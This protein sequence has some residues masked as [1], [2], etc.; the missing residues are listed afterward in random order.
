MCVLTS[1]SISRDP[2]SRVSSK[3]L[4]LEVGGEMNTS[5]LWWGQVGQWAFG[6]LEASGWAGPHNFPDWPI[7]DR[8][9]GP[10][11]RCR[12]R[13]E[14]MQVGMEQLW[15]S[16]R[17]SGPSSQDVPVNRWT[18]LPHGHPQWTTSHI[19]PPSFVCWTLPAASEKHAKVRQ[20]QVQGLAWG[21]PQGCS[22]EKGLELC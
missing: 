6:A 21:G 18:F 22:Q 5:G 12:W 8:P 17:V 7:R 14:C 20:Q 4:S 16:S 9:A 11:A 1:F 13:R 2:S 15:C 3:D 10:E 19:L